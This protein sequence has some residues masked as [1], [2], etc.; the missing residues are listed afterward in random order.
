MDDLK[1]QVLTEHLRE[2]RQCL[3]ISIAAILA[4]FALCYSFIKDIGH[5]FLKP[6]FDVLP[7]DTTL[8]FTTYQ[9][10]FFFT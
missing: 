6:L 1:K 8:V 4:G 2:L 5:W 7:K 10:A 9:E 3:I